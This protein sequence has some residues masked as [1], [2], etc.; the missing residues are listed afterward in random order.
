M[1]AGPR[2][3]AGK[4]VL[5][6]GN[7]PR[8]AIITL[9]KVDITLQENSSNEDTTCALLCS[10]ANRLGL[11]SFYSDINIRNINLPVDSLTNTCP[12]ILV[13]GDSNAHSTLWGSTSNNRR[14]DDWE[15]LMAVSQLSL[16]NNSNQYTFSN[17]LGS[18][19]IDLTLTN[20]CNKFDNWQNTGLFNGSDHSILLCTSTYI[21]P[22]V[23][24]E[25]QNIER[26]DWNAFRSN[27]LPL[28]ETSI[29]CTRQ[30]NERACQITNNIKS[31][32]NIACPPK[33]PFPGRPCKWW[34]RSLSNLL[35]K[36]NIA[37]KRA[38]KHHG[39]AIGT[40]AMCIKKALARLFQKTMRTAK[41]KNWED[42]VSNLESTRSISSLFKHFKHRSSPNIPL[43]SHMGMTAKNK[44]ENLEILRRS[45]FENSTA[46]YT[47][48]PGDDN[49]VS[50]KLTEDLDSFLN[51]DLLDEAIRTLPNGKAPGPDGIKNEIIKHLTVEYKKELLNL[52][53]RE[54]PL[55][56]HT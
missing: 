9:N 41:Q 31:A 30:L 39:T 29:T 24:G 52:F 14:G 49:R 11:M 25:V 1:R 51:V 27:L 46:I 10:K 4:T 35:R 6:S 17:H 16:L 36:K 34:T 3:L 48:N 50:D 15:E 42:F 37:A 56:I 13:A 47:T 12:T 19:C 22:H 20:D 45:H 23:E 32:F 54:H 43:L 28:E 38:R 8:A 44:A 40:R 18:S 21:D 33:P 53:K 2:A 7:N 5:F 26:T 55:W